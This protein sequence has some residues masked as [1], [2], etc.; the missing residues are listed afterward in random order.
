M[1]F[2]TSTEARHRGRQRIA[3]DVV[4]TLIV[5]LGS[6]DNKPPIAM[7]ALSARQC[8]LITPINKRDPENRR[9]IAEPEAVIRMRIE[10]LLARVRSWM[11]HAGVEVNCQETSY[12][13]VRIP[14]ERP[15]LLNCQIIVV[16]ID[17]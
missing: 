9:R 2:R 13:G 3:E 5:R 1:F 17:S 7:Y 11:R 6:T 15:Q 4:K 10:I 16:R 14:G 8:R 12:I